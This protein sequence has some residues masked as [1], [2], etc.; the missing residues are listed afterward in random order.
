MCFKANSLVDDLLNSISSTD[1]GP[2]TSPTE[3]ASIDEKILGL[4]A[5]GS[6]QQPLSDPKLFDNYCVAYTS[7][8]P[9]RQRRGAPAGG[10]FRGRIGRL[11][12][13]SRGIFQHILAPNT[14]VNLVA[15]KLFGIFKGAVGLKA[16]LTPLSHADDFGPSGIQV[17]F[18]PPRVSLGNLIFRF[19][20]RSTIRLKTTYLD[21]RIRI[22]IGSRGSLFVFSKGEDAHNLVSQEWKLLF[23]PRARLLPVT[24]VPLTLAFLI[25][26][27]IILPPGAVI[28]AAFCV[29]ILAHYSRATFNDSVL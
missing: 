1:G 10:R 13:L 28:A 21:D 18:E 19:G 3:R 12:F 17:D 4:C 8:D 5:L 24:V 2:L 15:F 20:P 9:S 29:A 22:G 27:A 26:A 11:L 23:S 14:V 7:F 25:C 16:T 6:Q